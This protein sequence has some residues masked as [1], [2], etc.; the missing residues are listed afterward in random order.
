MTQ[1]FISEGS[2]T[3]VTM[4]FS[5]HHCWWPFTM[6]T[7]HRSTKRLSIDYSNAKRIF[8]CSSCNINPTSSWWPES[9]I[10]AKMVTLSLAS[11]PEVTEMGG[12]KSQSGSLRALVSV[13]T[14]IQPHRD[15][16]PYNG[17]WFR[18]HMLP[19][20]WQ[21]N[22]TGYH[23]QAAS[24]RGILSQA[25]SFWVVQYVTR[26]VDSLCRGHISFFIK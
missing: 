20:G 1:T 16:Q 17:H 26:Q 2:E 8:P 14:P 25:G 23:L 11:D 6:K 3:L 21:P 22:L 13:T 24:L 10:P 5:G 4:C 12:P 7:R 18:L 9:I 15:T 19:G